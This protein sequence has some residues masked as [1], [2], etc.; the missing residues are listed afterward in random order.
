MRGPSHPTTSSAL[1]LYGACPACG[2]S[3]DAGPIPES[4]REHYGPPY[5]YSRAIGIEDPSVYDGV[6]EYRCPDCNA[7][8]PR[9]T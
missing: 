2:S 1:D 6:S 3:W 9:F 8:F 7:T 4:V 5:R